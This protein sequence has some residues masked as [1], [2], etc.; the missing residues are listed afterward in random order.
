V[1]RG[2]GEALGVGKMSELGGAA[3][4]VCGPTVS[5]V[6]TGKP[7]ERA[8]VGA[9]RVAPGR[10]ERGRG[11]VVA[12]GPS[13]W[14]MMLLPALLLGVL[15]LW[16][17]SNMFRAHPQ[18]E[19]NNNPTMRQPTGVQ[20]PQAQ[21][22]QMTEPQRP[23]VQPENAAPPAAAPPPAAPTPAPGP[24]RTEAALPTDLKFHFDTGTTRMTPDS[25][26]SVDSLLSYMQENPTTRIRIE[27]FADT[28]GNPTANEALS[29]NRA[30][31]LRSILVSR[32]IQS[33]RV[34]AT[35]MGQG[36]PVASNDNAP[37]RAQNRR[38][39]V[40]LIH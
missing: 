2:L 32:G 12:R 28:T 34:E 15:A 22:P 31:A 25:K 40:T 11:P 5:A 27:G 10:V 30:R 17:L 18:S 14:P 21:H 33:S 19:V 29:V 1:P 39:E 23:G 4:A 35:G 16:G 3:A 7:A 38:A 26:D 37:D 6:D 36:H 8:A 20:E 24:T 9:E 13:R